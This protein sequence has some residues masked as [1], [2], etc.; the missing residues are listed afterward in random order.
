MY[1]FQALL[2]TLQQDSASNIVTITAASPQPTQQQQT[3]IASSPPQTNNP[4]IE[5]LLASISSSP[6]QQQY[7]PAPSDDLCFGNQGGFG[8]KVPI[9]RLGTPG[10]ANVRPVKIEKRTSHN[11]IE[12]RYRL[13][14]NDKIVELKNLLSGEDSK[15]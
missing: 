1:I 7:S 10:C 15:V 8:D 12:K 6:P 4:A 11:A 14:I 3:V 2:Q 9:S 13:S 5:T